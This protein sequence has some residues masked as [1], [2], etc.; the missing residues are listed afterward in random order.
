MTS[1]ASMNRI[2]RLVFNEALGVWVAV[3]EKSRGRGKCGRAASALLAVLA[4]LSPSAHAANAADAT[5]RGGA[6]TVATVGNTTTIQQTSQRLALDWTQLSTA[7]GEALNFN[8]PNAQAIALNR[9]TGSSPSTF[10]GSLTANG[11]V[12]ILNPNGILFGAGSQVNVGGIV[13]ST[14]GM[15]PTDFMNGS[16]TF[17]KTTG[18]G[19]VVNQGSMTAAQG[20]YLALLAPEVRNEGVM[21]ASLGTALLAA[22]NKV[23]LN[24]NNGSL[25]SYSIDQGAINALAENKQLVK[26]DGG[27]VLLSAKALDSLTTAT[28]NNT[29]IIEAKTLQ[30]IAGRIMLMGDMEHG[31]VNVGGTLDASAA[32]G[33]GGF[34]ETSAAKVKV[35]DTARVTTLA[36]S[37]QTGTW[38]IDPTDF[39]ISA[40]GGD[41]TGAALGSQLA[42]NNITLATPST[43]TGNGDMRVN[44][45]VT[46]SSN[47]SLTLNA[48]RNIDF[49]GGGSLNASG[50]TSRVNLNAGQGGAGAVIGGAGVALTANTLSI[51]AS[52]GIGSAATALQTNVNNLRLNNTTSGGVY[53]HN[54]KDVTVAA[55]S[56]AGDVRISTANGANDQFTG[57][58]IAATN[59]GSITVGTV[60]GMSGITAT[61]TGNVTLTTGAGGNREATSG[62]DPGF[63]GSIRVDQ[64][65]AAGGSVGLYAGMSGAGG[66]GGFAGVT[67]NAG[68]SIVVN[69]DITAGANATL[70]AGGAPDCINPISCRAGS[71]GGITLNA[72]LQTGGS[73]SLAAGSGG[74]A[75]LDEVNLEDNL[76]WGGAG[77]SVVV[78]ALGRL[79]AGTSGTL[80]AGAGGSNLT[81]AEVQAGP[82]GSITSHGALSAGTDLLLRA[83]DGGS[84]VG[85]N[86]PVYAQGTG[87][88]VTTHAVVQAG[89]NLTLRAGHG[90]T[91]RG[92]VSNVAAAAGSVTAHASLIAGANALLVAGN[93]GTLTGVAGNG[94]NGGS[95]A[96]NGGL[97][98]GGTAT[99][100]GG[101]G[102]AGVVAG[103]GGNV[104]LASSVSAAATGDALRISGKN[105]INTAGANALQA[106]NG[107]WIVWS[108]SPTSNSFGGIQSGNAALW[109]TAYNPANPSVASPG[110]R[111]VFSDANSGVAVVAANNISKTYGD[112]LT[113]SY[114]YTAQVAGGQDFGNAF[115]DARGAAVALTGTAPT[116]SSAG[117]A[118]TATRTGGNAGG[119]G[120]D[121]TTG[122]TGATA[123]GY[124]LLAGKGTLTVAARPINI[125]GS[126][127]YNSNTAVAAAALTAGNTRNG[128]T[129]TLAGTGSVAD[130]NVANGK[131][132]SLGT[133]ALGGAAAVNYTLAGGA[134]SV[135][136]TP[137]DLSL[138]V[139]GVNKVYDGTTAASVTYADNRIAGDVLSF[140]SSASFSDK[141]VGTAKTVN[142]SGLTQTGLDAGN[143][144]LVSP[145]SGTSSA[146]ITP[147]LLRVTAND[148][149]RIVGGAPYAGGNGVVYSG[150]VG[151]EA[152][153]VLT[154]ALTYGGSS[155]GAS[156]AGTYNIRP[157]GLTAGNYALSFADGSL[158]LTP[159]P[160]VA[161]P[162]VPVPAPTPAPVISAGPMAAALGGTALVPAFAGVLQVVANLGVLPLANTGGTGGGIGGGGGTGVS[163][164]AGTGTGASPGTGGRVVI[165]GAPLSPQARL[166]AAANNAV[167]DE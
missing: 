38:L 15:N 10:L 53:A 47:N 88:S 56:V 76:A 7:A 43:G 134:A 86:S 115:T 32:T 104:V 105:F 149:T 5:I 31:T 108:A 112:A 61:G 6:G 39:T 135:N 1:H 48:Q 146:N 116:F 106:A 148:D 93:G 161:P 18:T 73:A 55:N 9:I 137:A 125:T 130:K 155:Q 160:V 65:V 127:T 98:A 94:A 4:I 103:A 114:G 69:A 44:D 49:S 138:T 30:N 12:F 80:A 62:T 19:S 143:Y 57:I 113:G 78:T 140:T 25:L 142:Y 29:G 124:S 133:L 99:L 151:G 41:I 83:G 51:D 81:L 26:A 110:N 145:T 67:G 132:L 42:S 85:S 150:L 71:G 70:A 82:G 24:L 23:T 97:T 122:L 102:G 36:A 40:T 3:A 118:A 147:A 17:T 163:G 37:G 164:G 152:P 50:A 74:M 128:D 75:P 129:L 2:Y 131:A 89:N 123:A 22:G 16:N 92:S 109:N 84:T 156:A 157:G 139:T 126:R 28:V 167:N 60:A 27:Q 100:T 87:G 96:L 33:N 159:A 153:S 120:Y 158:L 162:P 13:A 21:T 141:N 35:L 20:G 121:I 111:F 107:R 72:L 91:S 90:G 58:E 95:V 144:S 119:A 117:A 46:W 45:T 77:G 136:I 79:N 59:G 101:S 66:F 63:G 64:A 68:G 34:I 54:A 166:N 154:G 52:T 11:Q 8:Q 165:G 14:L